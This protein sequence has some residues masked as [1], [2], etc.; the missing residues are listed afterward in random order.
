MTIEPDEAVA[1]GAQWQ[2]TLQ[3]IGYDSGSTIPFRFGDRTIEF[4]DAP[5]WIA[6]A[7]QTASIVEGE[8][9]EITVTYAR[10]Y[11][12][13]VDLQTDATPAELL[14]GYTPQASLPVS[15]E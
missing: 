5:G 15:E 14:V 9:T 7:S 4:R 12:Y 6:P 3:A 1:A 2:F 8:L 10:S 11:S 13:Q